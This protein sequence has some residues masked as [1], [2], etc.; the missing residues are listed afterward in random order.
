M[1]IVQISDPHVFAKGELME[2]RVDTARGLR[3]ALGIATRLDPDLILMTGDLVNDGAAEQYEHL[4]E[5]LATVE[6]TTMLVAGNHDDRSLL[7][8]LIAELPRAVTPRPDDGSGRIE[9]DHREFVETGGPRLI[10]VDTVVTGNHHGCID[11]DQLAD[12]STRLVADETTLIA[13]HHPPYRSGIDFMDA[14]GLQGGQ[15]EIDLLQE[16]PEVL[17]VLTGHLHRHAVHVDR[18]VTMV[19][20]PSSA[21]QVALDLD[22]GP[23]TYTDEPGALLVHRVSGDSMTSHVCHLGHD[24]TWRPSW[25][26]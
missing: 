23:T 18:N 19:T 25:A 9:Y 8:A 15:A 16:H 12:L 3:A 24:G 20:A 21:A 6:A 13:Q 26:R 14:F 4:H 17:A 2:G 1:L 7:R 22:G 10:V 11:E 5:I